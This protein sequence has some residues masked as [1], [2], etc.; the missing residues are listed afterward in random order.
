M[1]H[2]LKNSLILLNS[3]LFLF[4]RSFVGLNFYGVRLGE[5]IVLISLLLTF[6]F[7]FNFK[8]FIN[9]LGKKLVT[10]QLLLFSS[11]FLSSIFSNTS[12]LTPYTYKSSSY[13][14]ALM[15]FYFGYLFFYDFKLS[16]KLMILLNFSLIYL[17]VLSSVNY[18]VFIKNFFETYSDKW[19]FNK[20]SSLMIAFVVIISLNNKYQYFN[21]YSNVYFLFVSSL[22]FPIILFQSRGSFIGLFIFVILQLVYLKRQ[23]TFKFNNYKL[24]LIFS[25]CIFIASSI[26]VTRQDITSE[27]F[28]LYGSGDS[29]LSQL[30]AQ[31][32]TNV[33]AFLSFYIYQD[34]IYSLDGN[35]NW[36]LQIWQDVIFDLIN[37]N[38]LIFGNGY[39]EVIP[40]MTI[41]ER[42]GNDGLNENVHNFL[43]NIIA[44]GGLFQLLLFLLV[45]VKIF[46]L[47]NFN[48]QLI[49]YMLSL[50]IVSF[51][52][53]SMENAHFPY[54]FYLFIPALFDNKNN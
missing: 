11:F 38:K 33:D 14:W 22:Y 50:F 36:R 45:W 21:K 23:K 51:F 16:K 39:K 43:V 25:V 10:L 7:L 9:N 6:L 31:K 37:D 19:D 44:R 42:K 28:S 15:W 4:G 32:D 29:V 47:N 54:L 53:A 2:K 35:V 26:N 41:Y 20:A 40:A 18:P 27:D 3:F 46:N 49:A 5:V 24:T 13:F 1:N 17:Y 30:T 48:I 8:F 52:D 12:L 34:R